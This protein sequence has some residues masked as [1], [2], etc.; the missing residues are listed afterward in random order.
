MDFNVIMISTTSP[1]LHATERTYRDVDLKRLREHVRGWVN[2]HFY[3]L[4]GDAIVIWKEIK[5][6]TPTQ[7]MRVREFMQMWI[8]TVGDI[9]TYDVEHACMDG[10]IVEIDDDQVQL[11]LRDGERIWAEKDQ[12]WQRVD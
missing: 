6:G 4:N 2:D 10:E 3:R 8:P 7:S 11:L 1:H 12:V 5:E 9:V